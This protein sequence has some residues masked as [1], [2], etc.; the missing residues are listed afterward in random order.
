LARSAQGIE[1]MLAQDMR[2]ETVG[3]GGSLA[4]G[5]RK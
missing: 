1:L 4:F 3:I 2:G 5:I